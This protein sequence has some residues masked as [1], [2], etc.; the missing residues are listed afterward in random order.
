VNTNANAGGVNNPFVDEGEVFRIDFVRDLVQVS[1]NGPYTFER[2]YST[3]GAGALFTAANNSTVTIYARDDFGDGTDFGGDLS[4]GNGTIDPITQ[5]TISWGGQ[6][7]LISVTAT[8][9]L[10]TVGGKDYYVRLNADGSVTVDGVYGE[11]GGTPAGTTIAVFT[12][13]GYSSLEFHGGGDNLN[14]LPFDNFQIGNF[15]AAV[16]SS[17]PV[18]LALPITIIDSDGDIA[19][20]QIELL[21][22][23][24]G[25]G[26]QDHSADVAGSTFTATS[27]TPHIIGSAFNDTLNGDAAANVLSGGEGNDIINGGGGNDFLSGGPGD[28]DLFGGAGDDILIGGA[29]SDDMTGDA[30]ADTFVIGFDSGSDG[31]KDI[32][33]DYN[34]NDGDSV[35]LTALLSGSGATQANIGTLVSVTDA[36][37]DTNIAI[38]GDVVATLTGYDHASP[39]SIL[40]DGEEFTIDL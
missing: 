26:I 40:I 10:Y 23:Q 1:Q 36:G 39:I 7:A 6:T 13:N 19:N 20:S 15:V 22:T 31:I 29:G 18:H 35:D 9:T 17:A 14:G 21:L 30:G 16:P 34:Y 28:D 38:D 2:H 33:A 11:G 8:S 25:Q 32:I 24:S 27:L 4:V 12:A 3:N 5:I 37:A